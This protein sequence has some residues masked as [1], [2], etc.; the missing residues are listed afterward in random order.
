M[1]VLVVLGLPP[2]AVTAKLL[3]SSCLKPSSAPFVLELPQ[4]RWPTVRSLS[5]RL[6]DRSTLFLK[7]AGTIIL[8]VSF[9]LWVLSIL[10]VHD[11]HFS[12]LA[13]SVIGKIGHFVEPVLK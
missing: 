2:S 7:K 5:L 12:D 8:A 1:P 3:K 9:V 13:G 10:P 4:Y 11:G 6:Y